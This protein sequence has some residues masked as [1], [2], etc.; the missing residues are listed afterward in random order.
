MSK[1]N[2][3]Q[4]TLETQS[5][6]SYALMRIVVGLLFAFHGMQKILGVL[7]SH[8][9]EVMSQIWIGGLIELVTGILV[10]VGLFTRASAFLASGTMAVAYT[11]F[12]WKF[13]FDERFFPS[14]NKGEMAV[15]YCFILLVIAT[16]G[17]GIWSL[18]SLRRTR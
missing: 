6:R 5:E 7:S 14:V 4:Q 11:Q 8:Q 12:H 13:A 17:A 9:P 2:L 1:S 18:E 15:L 10:A 16:K 3:F